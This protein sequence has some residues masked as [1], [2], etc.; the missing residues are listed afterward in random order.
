MPWRCCDSGNHRFR[1]APNSEHRP[2]ELAARH[3]ASGAGDRRY[4]ERR[5]E[6][7]TNRY[8]DGEKEDRDVTA[9]T[10]GLFVN[11]ESKHKDGCAYHSNPKKKLCEI[12]SK[13]VQ[14][15]K[16]ENT[17]DERRCSKHRS[18]FQ[19]DSLPGGAGHVPLRRS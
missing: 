2:D 19:D 13:S 5:A 9:A 15:A 14:A 8:M 6:A 12:R 4:Q 3:A 10:S 1:I 7:P 18:A 17:E 11:C 16:R